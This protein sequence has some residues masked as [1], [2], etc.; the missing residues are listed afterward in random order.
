MLPKQY[1]AANYDRRDCRGA[2]MDTGIV[3]EY[4]AACG[5][6]RRS[7]NSS[8]ARRCRAL[9]VRYSAIA[10]AVLLS[11][12]GCATTSEVETAALAKTPVAP[13]KARVTIK[14]TDEILYAGAPATIAL[15][16]KEVADIAVGGTAIV[17]VPAGSNVLAAS[18]WS[19]PGTYSLKL[20]AVAGHAYA[21]E[22]APR[23]S[24]FGPSLFGPVG[25]LID[26]SANNGNAGAFE[27]RVVDA[28][29][30]ATVGLRR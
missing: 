29:Q 9:D 17:D 30:A 8:G 24:S 5:S 25:A 26:S 2:D 13:G 19:Y 11:L 15:N 1:N 16:G 28:A 6:W 18:A 10:A 22:V 21:L 14:R 20:D 27:M 23:A 12:T 7:A 4:V 3:A